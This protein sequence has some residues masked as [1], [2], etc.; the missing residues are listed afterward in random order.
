MLENFKET[1]LLKK[2]ARLM[3]VKSR[4]NLHKCIKIEEVV[5]KLLAPCPTKYLVVW[6]V[7]GVRSVTLTDIHHLNSH[8]LEYIVGFI[9]YSLYPYWDTLR[10]FLLSCDVIPA[11]SREF[12]DAYHMYYYL[13]VDPDS[14]FL[15]SYEPCII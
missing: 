2:L 13:A 14:T 12:P 11:G 4:R 9:G 15:V 6:E 5:H 3:R 7:D 8:D 10:K 1:C